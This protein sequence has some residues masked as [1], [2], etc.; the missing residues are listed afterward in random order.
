MEESKLIQP[1]DRR[2]DVSWNPHDESG[3]EIHQVEDTMIPDRPTGIVGVM[4]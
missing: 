2:P 3:S 4:F 1:S